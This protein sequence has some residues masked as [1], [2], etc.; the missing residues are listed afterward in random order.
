VLSAHVVIDD[1][2]VSQA[3]LLQRRLGRLVRERYAIDHSTLQLECEGCE[4]DALY[5]D[6][7]RAAPRPLD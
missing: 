2:P 4:P 5:C 7:T 6:I 3:A 1:V